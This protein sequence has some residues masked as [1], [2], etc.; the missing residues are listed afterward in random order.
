VKNDGRRRGGERERDITPSLFAEVQEP[1][2]EFEE[3]LSSGNGF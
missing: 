1:Q 3:F 2:R